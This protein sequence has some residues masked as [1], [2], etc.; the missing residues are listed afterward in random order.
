MTYKLTNELKQ[1][2]NNI[3]VGKYVCIDNEERVQ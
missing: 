1:L 3:V 2:V